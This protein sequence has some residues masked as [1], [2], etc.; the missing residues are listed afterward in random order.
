MNQARDTN[1]LTLPV[2]VRDHA[3]GA[4]NADIVLVEYGDYQCPRCRAADLAIKEI[5][6]QLGE[7]L[8]FVFRHFPLSHVYSSAQNAAEAAEVAGMQGKFWEMHDYLFAHQQALDDG[9]LVEYAVAL[10]LDVTQFLRDMSGHIYA[11]R[12]QAD[13]LSG[14]T[15][16][17]TTTPTFFI[18]SVRYLG[19]WH[20]EMLLAAVTAPSSKW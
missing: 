11:D 16:G 3:Q 4:R 9:H 20:L 14:L 13:L 12:V 2:T 17:V 18:N 1:K 19:N 10:G 6:R 5:Q 7:Q 15:S 8:C